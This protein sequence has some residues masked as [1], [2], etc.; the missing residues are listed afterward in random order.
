M[1]LNCLLCCKN[2]PH[3][4]YG[5]WWNP[6][7]F[8]I[9]I[10]NLDLN[11]IGGFLWSVIIESNLKFSTCI[12]V[13]TQVFVVVRWIENSNYKSS[14][15]RKFCPIWSSFLYYYNLSNAATYFQV[16]PYSLTYYFTGCCK[17]KSPKAK[18][19]SRLR[20]FLE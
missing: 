8:S 18:F 4:I 7:E 19:I 12:L 16:C 13:T 17:Q 9:K 15:N 2:G 14:L 10:S 1:Y 11:W 6:S 3:T 5:Q 20:Q